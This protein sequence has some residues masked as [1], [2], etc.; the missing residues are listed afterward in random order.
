MIRINLTP[1]EELE[2]PLW[3]LPDALIVGLVVLLSY[4]GA[5]FYLDIT[6]QQIEEYNGS[7]EQIVSEINVLQPDVARYNDLTEKIAKLQSKNRSL[8]RITESK[9]VRYLPVILLE[10]LQTLKPDGLWFKRLAFVEPAAAQENNEPAGPGA[11][12]G[13]NLAE[14]QGGDYPVTIEL[15]GNAYD[16]IIIAE[17]MTALKATHMQNFDLSDVRTQLYFSDVKLAFAEGSAQAEQDERRI[18]EFQLVL[19]FRER[20]E[21][22]RNVGA[23][24]SRLI[25][26][27]Q[28]W[29]PTA[30]R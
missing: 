8:K 18:L 1:I 21:A 2:N 12:T 29:Q 7:A 16:N 15:V 17:F 23:R 5:Y 28:K 20:G 26:S 6:R 4:G 9:L 22:T 10:S 14:V 19:K 30:M 3:W 13:T 25:K 27:I 24:M 11:A